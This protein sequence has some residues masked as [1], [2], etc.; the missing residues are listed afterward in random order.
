[1]PELPEVETVRRGLEESLVGLK[2]ARF[3][4][5]RRDLR[6]PIPT[7][8]KKR[9]EGRLVVSV[10]RRSKY[11]LIN[12][13]DQTILLSHLGMSGR[14]TILSEGE[15]SRP[16]RFAHGGLIGTGDGHHDWIRVEFSDGTEA[17]YSDPRR[18][19]FV[20]LIEPGTESEHPMLSKLGPDPLPGTLTPRMLNYS[21]SGKKTSLKSALLDQK[22]IAGLGNIYVC[23]ALS[24][25][26]LSPRRKSYTITSKKGPTKRI[27][28]L[29]AAIHSIMA[30]AIDAGGSTLND[31]RG[32]HGDEA[33]G[34]FPLSFQVYGRE[35]EGCLNPGCSG[36]V[37]RYVQSGRSTFACPR[38][39]R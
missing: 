27:H 5:R 4:A 3:T 30:E 35:G 9:L 11:L 33:L 15:P 32:V 20:D 37:M 1:M 21:L 14:W 7:N 6:F 36:L 31:Y 23:E 24:R 13:D 22:I 38:C 2:V 39:Q 8:L 34:Y 26:R 28:E 29:V 10:R 25:A 17:I 18:F 12:M 16:G 19:G